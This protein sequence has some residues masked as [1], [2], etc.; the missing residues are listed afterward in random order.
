MFSFCTEFDSDFYRSMSGAIK[1]NNGFFRSA[2]QRWFVRNRLLPVW[3]NGVSNQDYTGLASA[4]VAKIKDWFGVDA[5]VGQWLFMVSAR[6]QWAPGTRAR[7]DV[8]W[9]FVTDEYG[10]VRKYKLHRSY[11]DRGTASS[12]NAAR[13][14]LEWSRPVDAALPM[15]EDERK[16]VAPMETGNHVGKE[17]K[18]GVFELTVDTVK[19]LGAKQVAY[20]V[21]AESYLTVMHDAGGN[22]VKS[23]GSWGEKVKAG[24]KIKIKATVKEHTYY[25]GRA[26][27]IVNRVKPA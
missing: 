18:R 24:D 2:K 4:D 25:K 5:S 1:S 21:C 13:T 19:F 3:G 10:V 26:E 6:V 20:G 27:T 14:E 16:E 12:I 17:G 7:R 9:A 8:E 22:T 11:T 15:F 23:F